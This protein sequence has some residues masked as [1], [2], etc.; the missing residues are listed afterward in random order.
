MTYF[1]NKNTILIF[2]FA[3]LKLVI[4][5]L[6]NTNYGLHRDEYL[7]FDE[8]QHLAWGFFEVPPMTPF[9]GAISDL[10]GGSVFAIRL[11]PALSGAIIVIL[12]CKLAKD[13]G[14][15][16]WGIF[17]TGFSLTFST[18]LLGT[19]TLF[20]PV[21]FNQLF[22]F[23][24]AYMVAQIIRDEQKWRWLTLGIFIGLGFL[25]KYSLAFY[26]IALFIA[27]LLTKERELL[28]NKY[29]IATIFIGFLIA[30]PNIIWQINHNLPLFQ[31][32][33]EL[34]ETQLIHMNWMLFLRS[35]LEFHLGFT[36]V[37]LFGLIGVF[38][39][40]ELQIY[41]CFGW[42]FL[43]VLLIVGGLQ[44]KAYYTLGSF[45]I[46]FPFGALSIVHYITSAKAK[47][48]LLLGIFLITVPFYPLAI[49]ILKVDNLKKYTHF[50]SEN[51][52]L[53]SI[54]RWEDGQYYDLPQDVADTHGWEELV[55]RV[56]AIYMALPNDTKDNCLIYA[57]NYGH[58]GALNYYREKY[59]L[60]EA[61]SFNSSYILWAKENIDFDNMIMIEDSKPGAS[62][63]FEISTLVDSIQNENAREKGYIYY[64]TKPK[65]DVSDAWKT[66]ILERK[67][68]LGM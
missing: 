22:W 32:M 24:V 44:G 28:K 25:T 54:L 66:I 41:K 30:L 8:G 29:F 59:Q 50:L 48:A 38:T 62:T 65:V 10:L 19:N 16:T 45:L 6:T 51:F 12:A 63:W 23:L 57:G 11:L 9:L 40:K 64:R 33:Q 61:Y 31:H 3:L 67:A 58:A 15:K 17:L 52:G 47:Y 26:L 2:S 43:F 46:L 36:L 39:I 14:G 49:P 68:E 5:F 7:Y 1:K 21:S 18:A 34:R 35:Q 53:D 42:A 37:W 13:L 20:Q 27:V 4:H 56:A 60:P 55:H